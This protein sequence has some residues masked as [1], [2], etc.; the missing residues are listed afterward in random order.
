MESNSRCTIRQRVVHHNIVS[1]GCAAS[2]NLF[3]LY[4]SHDHEECRQ[5]GQIKTG[6]TVINNLRYADDRHR[7][8]DWLI[9][10]QTQLFVLT[11]N[12]EKVHA[13]FDMSM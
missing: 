1:R 12:V 10:V 2:P 3:T 5:D 7:I 13:L 6:G 4:T 11:R 9:I 8:Q